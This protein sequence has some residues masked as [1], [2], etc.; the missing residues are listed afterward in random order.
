MYSPCKTKST[1]KVNELR[2]EFDLWF[3]NN[4]MKI[5]RHL[6]SK[7]A[8]CLFDSVLSLLENWRS[9]PIDLRLRS[10]SWT[11]NVVSRGSAWGM[12]MWKLFEDTKA[13]IDSYGMPTYM[14]YLE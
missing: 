1:I 2:T 8:N 12:K 6:S 13:N 11:Q 14:D 10:I 5:Q 7:N 9:K 4:G 3:L